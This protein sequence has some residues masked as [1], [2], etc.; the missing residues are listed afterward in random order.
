MSFLLLWKQENWC[1]VHCL[2][3]LRRGGRPVPCNTAEK[4][5]SQY[6]WLQRLHRLAPEGLPGS[7]HRRHMMGQILFGG[8]P[9]S[10]IVLEVAS[11]WEAK[12][13]LW[14]SGG[15][16]P[17]PRFTW[18]SCFW[19]KPQASW[20]GICLIKR[21]SAQSKATC[22]LQEGK[23]KNCKAPLSSPSETVETR[24]HPQ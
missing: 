17:A 2:M 15:D 21:V 1:L 8:T 12:L 16:Y 22:L 20:G 10:F 23:S 14:Q 13:L 5:S 24:T 7:G 4:L 9:A 18:T 6:L 3:C 19:I 11:L